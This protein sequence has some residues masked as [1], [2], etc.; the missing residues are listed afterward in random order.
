M[1]L[2]KKKRLMIIL[3]SISVLSSCSTYERLNTGKEN[4]I[5]Y[6]INCSGAMLT[7]NSCKSTASS[8]CLNGYEELSRTDAPHSI[9]I[10][11]NIT[12]KCK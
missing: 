12:I 6:S 9:N 11:R 3:L 5:K 1:I 7:I 2:Y 10:N 8:L 4:E